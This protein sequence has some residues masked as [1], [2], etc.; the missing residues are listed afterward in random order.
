MEVGLFEMT[1]EGLQPIEGGG[2]LLD[3][4]AMPRPGTV[5]APVLFGS[6]CLLTEVQGLV[7]SGFLGSA[8]RKATGIDANRL[9]DGDCGFGTALWFAACRSGH[10]CRRE[11]RASRPPNPRRICLWPWRLP[12]PIC[13]NPSLRM[14]LRLVNWGWAAKFVPVPQSEKRLREAACDL[15][16]KRFFAAQTCPNLKVYV[17]EICSGIAEAVSALEA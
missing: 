3:T 8:K 11:R 9:A 15:A 10:L 5:A 1:G 17:K 4:N 6:R 13:E 14:R 16:R 12:V 2:A 7:V